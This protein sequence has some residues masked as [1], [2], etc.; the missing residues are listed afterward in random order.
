MNKILIS[1]MIIT[2][3]VLGWYILS[4]A[5]TA[6]QTQTLQSLQAQQVSAQ[7]CISNATSGLSTCQAQYNSISSDILSV[8]QAIIQY[9]N[10]NATS[11]SGINWDYFINLEQNLIRFSQWPA[12]SSGVNWA[13]I[14]PQLGINCSVQESAVNWSNWGNCESKGLSGGQPYGNWPSGVAAFYCGQGSIQGIC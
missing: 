14:I 4:H 3:C 6:A 7:S 9:N 8:Q 11:I 10:A 2:G 5:Q 13:S 12:V 1:L